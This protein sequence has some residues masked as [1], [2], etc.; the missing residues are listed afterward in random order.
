MITSSIIIHTFIFLASFIF[1]N[2]FKTQQMELFATALGH[3]FLGCTDILALRRPKRLDMDKDSFLLQQLYSSAP[4]ASRSPL[5][6]CILAIRGQHTP[7]IN[8]DLS[9]F[10]NRLRTSS[11]GAPSAPALSISALSSD[12]PI[13]AVAPNFVF[14]PW[15]SHVWLTPADGGKKRAQWPSL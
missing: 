2:K 8:K 12:P 3:L 13:S 14:P 1:I 9:V 6:S 15:N 10:N 11:A 4:V 5:S 7:A